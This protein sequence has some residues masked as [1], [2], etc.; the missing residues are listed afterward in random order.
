MSCIA[1]IHKGQYLSEN[2]AIVTNEKNIRISTISTPNSTNKN[3]LINGSL[4]NIVPIIP[5]IMTAEANFSGH[6]PRIS[7]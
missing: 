7:A 6:P 1:H 3:L 5:N 2:K 4:N